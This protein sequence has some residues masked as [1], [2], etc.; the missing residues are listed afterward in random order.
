MMAQESGSPTAQAEELQQSLQ[1][2]LQDAKQQA[3]AAAA[4][5]RSVEQ[6]FADLQAQAHHVAGQQ[7][8]LQVKL[9][10]HAALPQ[11]HLCCILSVVHSI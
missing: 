4:E 1:E 11:A 3:V 8:A 7:D 2:E 5:R 9:T 6:A 10:C